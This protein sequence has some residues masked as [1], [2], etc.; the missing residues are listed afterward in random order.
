MR[1][2]GR[3][4]K[5]FSEQVLSCFLAFL[6]NPSGPLR[7][8]VFAFQMPLVAA[9]PRWVFAFQMPFGCGCAALGLCPFDEAQGGWVVSLPNHVSAS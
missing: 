3:Q 1:K 8:R 5:R 9:P 7:L 4:E 6:M 2:T